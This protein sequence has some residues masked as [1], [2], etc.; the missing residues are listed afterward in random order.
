MR[1][2][3]IALSV[4]ALVVLG[5]SAAFAQTV[6]GD[7]DQNPIERMSTFVSDALDNLV[8]D[9]TITADQADAVEGALADAHEARFAERE[10]MRAERAEAHDAIMAALDDGVITADEAATL[11][12]TPLTDTDGPLADAW[13]DGELT[14]DELDE[15]R[16]E[17]GGRRGPGGHSGH[18]GFGG[19]NGPGQGVIDS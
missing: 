8:D 4:S 10:A 7:A 11:P 17:F 14:Q 18:G 5:A 6:D 13:A 15:A 16:A 9:G 19:Q 3:F 12:D 2:T 1:K